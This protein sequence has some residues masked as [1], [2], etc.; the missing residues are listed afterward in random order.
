MRFHIAN[1][2]CGG[3]A[4]SV[5]KAIQSVDSAATVEASQETRTIDVTSNASVGELI[6]VLKEAGY[7][8]KPVAAA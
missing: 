2:A 4:Q 5:T 7:P 1:M 8:A 6:A 3:C